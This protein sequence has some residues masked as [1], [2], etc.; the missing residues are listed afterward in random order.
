[1]SPNNHLSF[2]KSYMLSLHEAIKIS[3][4][5]HLAHQGS[6]NSQK[7]DVSNHSVVCW[8]GSIAFPILPID[9]EN[10][11]QLSKCT[12]PIIS[13]PKP[14][15]LSN[16][17]ISYPIWQMSIPDVCVTSERWSGI[18]MFRCISKQLRGMTCNNTVV[19][20][21]SN[22]MSI[23]SHSYVSAYRL[24]SHIL[25][26]G[27]HGTPMFWNA[28][29]AVDDVA[30][31]ACARIPDGALGKIIATRKHQALACCKREIAV[32][33]CNTIHFS[34][35]S[36]II[37]KRYEPRNAKLYCFVYKCVSIYLCT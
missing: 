24:Q 8:H 19:M 15:K 22:K 27:L 10:L 35:K 12:L 17:Q 1:M 13:I 36:F 2:S 6:R 26:C 29:P 37:N 3:Y 11:S 23:I 30:C 33:I 28:K 25:R 5:Y 32:C 18:A 21:H 4:L 34:T 14:L 20:F 9:I 7:S 16:S 31:C